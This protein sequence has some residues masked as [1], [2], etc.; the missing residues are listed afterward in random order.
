MDVDDS[1]LLKSIRCLCILLIHSKSKSTDGNIPYIL[2]S[3]PVGTDPSAAPDKSN[4]CPHIVIFEGDELDQYFIAIEQCLILECKD[5]PTA[6]FLLI[7][8]HYVFNIS[9][10]PK[11]QDFFAFIESKLLNISSSTYKS[12]S[13]VALS[14]INGIT[15]EHEVLNG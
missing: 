4:N 9:Y 3:V 5:I 10:Q 13:P 6:L 2:R 15:R 11:A 12:K 7:A 1:Y 14:H 8:S